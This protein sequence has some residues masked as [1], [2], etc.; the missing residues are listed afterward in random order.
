[1][2][3]GQI[4]QGRPRV[5]IKWTGDSKTNSHTPHGVGNHRA[6]PQSRLPKASAVS[7]QVVPSSF[8]LKMVLRSALSQGRRQR[9]A[10]GLS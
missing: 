8:W 9:N 10:E 3:A 5:L 1:M 6:S 2:H 7:S 4:L